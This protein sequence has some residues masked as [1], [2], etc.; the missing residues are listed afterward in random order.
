[1]HTGVSVTDGSSFPS[2]YPDPLIP[3]HLCVTSLVTE[4]LYLNLR[5]QTSLPGEEAKA[6]GGE[7]T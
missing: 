7:G 3:T 2:S 6:E 5:S 1:M 4:A